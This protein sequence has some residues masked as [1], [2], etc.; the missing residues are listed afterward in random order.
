MA[1]PA[2]VERPVPMAATDLLNV[3]HKA[4]LLMES[5]EELWEKHQLNSATIQQYDAQREAQL[6][7][8]IHELIGKK[9][10]LEKHIQERQA[11]KRA[12]KRL[13]DEIEG[14]EVEPSQATVDERSEAREALHHLRNICRKILEVTKDEYM[15]S[16]W[17]G[18]R[19]DSTD[20]VPHISA[21]LEANDT[22][23]LQEM[24]VV[25]DDKGPRWSIM[26]VYNRAR[27]LQ[28]LLKDEKID[29]AGFKALWR[30]AEAARDKL[31]HDWMTQLGR[32]TAAEAEV[33][34]L[35]REL[36]GLRT[37][38]NG[39]DLDIQRLCDQ[40]ESLGDEKTGMANEISILTAEKIAADI[41][42]GQLAPHHERNIRHL[43]DEKDLE[44]QGLRDETESL[45]D[46]ETEM[47]DDIS[48]LTAETTAAN[49]KFEQ[50][51]K[52][53]VQNE[54]I[55][56]KEL[57]QHQSRLFSDFS[58]E[59]DGRYAREEL[60]REIDRST[61]ATGAK[62]VTEAYK[63]ALQIE[64]HGLK[65]EDQQ[66]TAELLATGSTLKG[67][68]TTSANSISS[69]VKLIQAVSTHIER[70][71]DRGLIEEKVITVFLSLLPNTP[72]RS[73]DRIA[74]SI[75]AQY[76]D[77][78]SDEEFDATFVPVTSSIDWSL[79]VVDPQ[80]CTIY[81]GLSL[82]NALKI[83]WILVCCAVGPGVTSTLNLLEH[84]LDVCK[85]RLLRVLSRDVFENKERAS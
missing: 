84:M 41:E 9:A 13:N 49:S 54:S 64:V 57:G 15:E 39:K 74:A 2:F 63:D 32:K 61:T 22:N 21:Y 16:E 83:L 72:T 4:Q 56:A 59:Y 81:P 18:V 20:Q 40:A 11:A 75:S 71:L 36:E 1:P 26:D 66:L 80:K 25:M 67:V 12:A 79:S 46:E 37:D 35:T 78:P 82:H 5:T 60:A 6:Q 52:D 23:E 68:R 70:L 47:E 10:V 30:T 62:A 73:V 14:E 48:I 53:R 51:A 69:K 31:S 33:K 34:R 24:R 50:L 28:L 55:W 7:D 45:G 27:E 42:L 43:R 3:V 44:I 19:R 29:A 65:D 85:R 77:P 8:Q 17:E 58:E 76:I 38:L